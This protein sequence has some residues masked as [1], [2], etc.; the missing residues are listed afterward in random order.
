MFDRIRRCGVTV[1][2]CLG[3]F[4]STSATAEDLVPAIR[5]FFEGKVR[6]LLVE[7]CGECHS[8][9][10]KQQR[11]GLLVDSLEGLLKGG[12]SGPAV[13]PG[14][15]QESLLMQAVRYESLEMPPT[16][17][18]AAVE[19]QIL[20]KWIALGAPWPGAVSSKIDKSSKAAK[21][22]V[23]DWNALRDSHWAWKSVVKP[24]LP[25]VRNV[26]WPQAEWDTLI[27]AKLEAAGML[28]SPAAD[29]RTLLRRVSLDL[30]GLPPTPAEVLDFVNDDSP[31]AFA[32]VV[33][34]LL[35]SPHYGERWARHWMDVARYSEGFGVGFDGD[36]K[37]QAY[38]Y[39]DWLVQAF[40]A[41]L[42]YDEF[43][44]QQIAGDLLNNPQAVAATGFFALGPVYTSD[45]GDPDSVSRARAETLDDRIDTLTRGLMAITVSCARCHD[46]KFDP[47]PT[48]D[49]YSLAGVFQ[50]SREIDRPL[51]TRTEIDN[52]EAAQR[53]IKENED[54]LRLFTGRPRRENREL[55]P[56]EKEHI[57]GLRITLEELRANAPPRTPVLHSLRDTGK[58]DMAVA[59]RGDL[60]RPGEL[61]PRRF[62]RIVAGESGPRFTQGSGRLELA[63]AVTEPGNPL[64]ARV[65]VNRVWRHH[66]GEGLVRTP[67]NFGALGEA[68]THPELLDW[69][70]AEFVARGWSIKDLHRRLLLSST[71]QMSSTMVRE[72]FD[73]DGDNRLWWRMSPRRLDVEAW[74][75][76]LLSVT[77][78]LD[79][80]L[81][82][83]PVDNLYSS[84][85]R[86]LYSVIS[87]NPDRFESMRFLRLFDF[88][89]PRATVA[90]RT[91]SLVP[92]QFLFMLNHPFMRERAQALAER[93]RSEGKTDAERIERAYLLLYSRVPT[94]D[95]RR[96]GE[97]FL[98]S[99]AQG[100]VNPWLQYAQ[101]LLSANELLFVP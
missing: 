42:P 67:D 45:G 27:L 70:T 101:V 22:G 3:I 91:S 75:D 56:E 99:Q 51:G 24:G 19:V 95:E 8:L 98:T 30:I 16:G 1:L 76:S 73:R 93:L 25:T 46:H 78:E 90:A 83:P 96:L 20:E 72:N 37:P 21:S 15:P 80:A 88:P 48:Q 34:R 40:N 10:S 63:Q 55:S 59:I 5:D 35:S 66:F 18:L 71:Y 44:R 50:N 13:V 82:G 84:R 94:S 39:R 28:P 9:S 100:N 68:P 6:P 77:G 54:L 14:K 11:A 41:D 12:E 79:T 2:A 38:L 97:L 81:G 47:I 36:E 92:Q 86:T 53:N 32:R 60:R 23:W 17:K 4:A 74:R 7:R 85:R 49:Y 64:T 69:L 31:S 61:A 89:I 29:R 52:Y 57:A 43:L 65:F 87:R 62:L 26:A 33:D 58:T